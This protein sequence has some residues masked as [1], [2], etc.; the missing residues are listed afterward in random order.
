MKTSTAIL[1]LL[2]LMIAPIACAIVVCPAIS[3]HDCC[4]KSQSF[5][6][7]P[8]DILSSAK[9]TLPAVAGPILT[10]FTV[11]LVCFVP[12]TWQSVAPDNRDLHLHNRVLRI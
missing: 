8:Y 10:A 7:C 2:G 12:D 5:A 4:P 3:A 6:A 1:A 9:A 11:Q